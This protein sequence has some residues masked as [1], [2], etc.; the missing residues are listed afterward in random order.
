MLEVI[1]VLVRIDQLEKLIEES[2]SE[3][4]NKFTTIAKH[5]FSSYMH[6]KLS[7]VKI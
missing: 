3:E 6:L 4:L 5:R 2:D 7:K 1:K